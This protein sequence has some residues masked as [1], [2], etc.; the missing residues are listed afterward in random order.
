M[1][2]SP[3]PPKWAAK[4]RDASVGDMCEDPDDALFSVEIGGHPRPG[5][6]GKWGRDSR[7]GAQV[8]SAADLCP[9]GLNMSS[10]SCLNPST[11]YSA[12]R[13]HDPAHETSNRV[14]EGSRESTASERVHRALGGSK[15]PA[16]A[17]RVQRALGANIRSA[18]QGSAPTRPCPD[19]DSV[20]LGRVTSTVLAFEQRRN[21]SPDRRI[22]QRL[23]PK[24][25]FPPP[26]CDEEQNKPASMQSTYEDRWRRRR[27]VEEVHE[28]LRVRESASDLIDLAK[29]ILEAY[30]TASA[31]DRELEVYNSENV[32]PCMI[33][34]KPVVLVENETVGGV[35]EFRAKVSFLQSQASN[36]TLPAEMGSVA[37]DV[38]ALLRRVETLLRGSAQN[39]VADPTC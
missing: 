12:R 24:P 5:H 4:S 33:S 9:V 38:A 3:K 14:S 32:P 35:D 25:R 28:E 18:S 2:T 15:E 31:N 8:H 22:L 26:E 16:A 7:V 30:K 17:E 11:Q 1:A 6:L 27:H 10:I 37:S 34:E 39:G 23:P 13:H 19:F 20:V 36:G 29:T 21:A